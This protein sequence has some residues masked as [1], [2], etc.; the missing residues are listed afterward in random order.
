METS[1]YPSSLIVARLQPGEELV[2][3]IKDLSRRMGV[4]AGLVIAIGGLS[5]LEVGVYKNGRYD[6]QTF[7]AGSGETI[8][9][10]SAI[11][12]VAL[13]DDGSPFPHVHVT[14]SLPNHQPVSGHLIK[15]IVNPL[16]ELF[17]VKASG[18]LRRTMDQSIGL[19]ALSL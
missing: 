15:G 1:L 17:I 13:G 3:A 12:S 11:G 14:A 5:H 18:Q 10:T 16:V 9:L 2:E 8:E 4:S 19:P 7:E 6:V